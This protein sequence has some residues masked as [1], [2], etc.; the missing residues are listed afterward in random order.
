MA[1]VTHAKMASILQRIIARP[2]YNIN[3]SDPFNL[4]TMQSRSGGK[5]LSELTEDVAINLGEVCKQLAEEPQ[6]QLKKRETI[7]IQIQIKIIEERLR[8]RKTRQLSE[9]MRK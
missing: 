5:K 6:N 1:T 4:F 8:K 3:F 9:A 2:W 7:K